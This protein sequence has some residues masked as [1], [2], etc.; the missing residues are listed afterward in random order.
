MP[1]GLVV[2]GDAGLLKRALLNLLLNGQQAIDS[3]GTVC[4]R[5]S[6]DGDRAV[7]EIVDDGCGIAADELE[8]V[9][10]VYYSGSKEG[11]GLGLPMARRILE[12]H[13]GTLDLSSTEGEG[14]TVRLEV[15]L[16]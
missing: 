2:E 1:D 13:G 11:S 12:E 16:A 15:P 4:I 14:T 10:D 3:S 9:F 7:L 6:R 8:Q 5:G